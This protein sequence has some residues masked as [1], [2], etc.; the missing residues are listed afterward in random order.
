MPV[1]A[2]VPAAFNI[3]V[4]GDQLVVVWSSSDL[5]T[6]LEIVDPNG[7]S[8]SVDSSGGGG[9][10]TAELTGAGPH[11]LTVRGYD[12]SDGSFHVVTAPVQTQDLVEGEPVPAS[13]PAV[14]DVDVDTG[15]LFSFTAEPARPDSVLTIQVNDPDGFASGCLRQF[16][17]TRGA[18]HG[19]H[20]RQHSRCASDHRRLRH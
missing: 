16:A 19:H 7:E 17:R 15:Q 20:R 10:E 18:R 11:L 5:D 9:V 3:E 12:N 2:S 13:A 4:S 8:S 1:T 6:F 14:F